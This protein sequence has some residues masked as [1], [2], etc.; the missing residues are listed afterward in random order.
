[1]KNNIE[2]NIENIKLE[3]D[4]DYLFKLAKEKIFSMI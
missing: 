3:N 4:F 1:M 2:L